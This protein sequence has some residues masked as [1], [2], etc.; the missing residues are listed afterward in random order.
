MKEHHMPKKRPHD[1][2]DLFMAPVLLDV[3]ERI[4]QLAQ[5][6]AQA[7]ADRVLVH[8]NHETS[9][10]AERRDALLATLTDG[11]ELHGWKAK[12]HDRGLRLTHGEHSVVLGLGP[13][14]RAYLS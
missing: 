13:E 9:D 14:L 8:V 3:D 2:A 1:R 11:L 4:N 7:L 10:G 6:D 5:L 12:W